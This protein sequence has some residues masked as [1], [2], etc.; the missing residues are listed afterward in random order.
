M[1]VA[2][3]VLAL[4]ALWILGVASW[5]A[6]EKRSPEATLAWIAVLVFLP[7]VGIPIYLLIGPRRLQRHRMRYGDLRLQL[8]AQVAQ[9]ERGVSLPPDVL[10]QVRLGLHL[11]EA[12]VTTASELEIYVGG[13][14]AFAALVDAIEGARRHVHLETYIYDPTPP[15]GACSSCSPTGRAPACACGCWSTTS[16]PAPAPASSLHS[17][18]PAARS[19]ASTR[20]AGRCPG[21][22][23][24]TSEPTARS[25]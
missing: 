25:S 6:L 20:R 23:G 8:A 17:S 24:S 13:E 16:A 18:P 1:E 3:V 9:I 5:L 7:L 12:P 11:D 22:A 19:P 14:T 10:R 4:E 21:A 15:A 2:V